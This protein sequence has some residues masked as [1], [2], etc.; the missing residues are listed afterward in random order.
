MTNKYIRCIQDV[1]VSSVL[2][3]LYFYIMICF[4]M[5]NAGNIPVLSCPGAA[6]GWSSFVL[7]EILSEFS[8]EC[9][10]R[11]F[12]FSVKPGFVLARITC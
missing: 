6:F 3:A 4:G 9:L 1:S 7:P 2:L 10:Q 5:Y 12:R 8:P 11:A